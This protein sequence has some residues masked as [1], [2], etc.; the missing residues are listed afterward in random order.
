M[1]LEALIRKEHSKAN[2]NRVIKWVGGDQRRFDELFRLY[3][4]GDKLLSQRAAWPL[5]EIAI[6]HPPLIRKHLSRLLQFAKQP[7]RHEAVKRNTLRILQF[8]PLPKRWHGPVMDDCFRFIA[9]PAEKPAVKAYSLT[10]LRNFTRDYPDIKQ[11]LITTIHDRWEYET[12][13]FHSCGR[14]ILEALK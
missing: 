10:I 7:G 3:V 9:S 2:C 14:K 8:V 13:A 1:D 4:T 12:P 6:A 5:G 11:E